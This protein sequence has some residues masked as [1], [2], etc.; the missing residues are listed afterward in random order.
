MIVVE[1]WAMGGDCGCW[2]LLLL[3]GGFNYRMV[4]V[5]EVI[6]NI[7]LTIKLISIFSLW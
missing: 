7:F 1:C 4:I 6:F 3:S 5:A 2:E